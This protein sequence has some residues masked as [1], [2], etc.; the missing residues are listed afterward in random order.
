[1]TKAVTSGE[2]LDQA[3]QEGYS[4]AIKGVAGVAPTNSRGSPNDAI[5]IRGIKLNLFSNYRI[6]GG[7]PTAGVITTPTE[8]KERI[9]TLKGA[10]ALMFGVASP[11]G[12][13]NLVTKRA[14]NIDVTNFAIAGNSFGQYGG[15]IDI[16][17]R[18]G[19]ERQ[20]GIRFNASGTHLE[21]GV[22]DTGGNG[23]FA[24]VGMDFKMTDRLTIS[25]DYEYYMKHVIENAGVSLLATVKADG[26]T[27]KTTD[28]ASLCHV[29]LTPVPNPRNL[30]TGTWNLYPPKTWNQQIRADF[31]ITDDWK[32]LAETGRSDAERTRYTVRIGGYNIVTGAGGV[33][34]VQFAGQ[35]YKNSFSRLESIAKFKTWFMTHDLTVGAS[36]TERDAISDGQISSLAT[37]LPTQNIFNPIELPAPVFKGAPTILPVQSSYDKGTYAYDTIGIGTQ[38][39]VLLGARRTKDDETTATRSNS[40]TTNSPAYGLLFDVM[41]SMTLFGSYLEGLEAG[42]TAPATAVNANEILPSAISK[43][44]EV[45]IRDSHLRGVSFNLSYFKIT[46]AN[47]VTDPVSKIFANSGQLDYTGVESTLSWEFLRRFTL[48]AAGQW[49]RVKQVT[50]DPTFNGFTPENT[51]KLLGNMSI[52]YKPP[53]LAGLSVNAGFNAVSARFMNNQQQGTIPGYALYTAGL[54]YTTRL[55][56]KRVAF[57]LNGDNLANRRY[58][59]SVQTGTYGIG[60]DRSFKFNTRVEL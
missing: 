35:H 6:N 51:P 48:N 46:R 9:E 31:L 49:L 43:Q 3:S 55:W 24:S 14:G 52:A 41:P 47:A 60:M 44:K 45:G 2:T 40:S 53:F 17:R 58:W 15:T 21:N 59:N 32:L 16:G 1:M 19:P 54:G 30:L 11:A 23:H 4:E 28:A 13:V 10:N 8:N 5:A 12:I 26:T 29:P 36:A 20:L 7:L 37:P 42:G 56:G 27:C 18:L 57:Q 25:G 39:K 38:W 33:P 50:S 34:T 22:R